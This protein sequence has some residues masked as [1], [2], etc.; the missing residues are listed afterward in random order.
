[1][2]MIIAILFFVS[3]MLVDE[4]SAQSTYSVSVSRHAAVPALSEAHVRKILEDASKMLQKNSVSNGDTDVA[5]DVTF[6]LVGPVRTFGSADTPPNIVDE[7]HR[8]AVHKVDSDV[9]GVDFH[10]EVVD[11]IRFCRPNLDGPFNGCAFPPDF[12]SIIVVHPGKHP[13]APPLEFPDHLLWAHEFGHLTGLGH[14][15]SKCALMTSCSV[16]DLASVTRVR[17]NNEECRCLRGGLGFCPLPAAVN[18]QPAD[19]Q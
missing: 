11:E 9:I 15:H 6:T 18:C 19:C 8:D 10:I 3:L 5:C 2:Q 14:R 12:R 16:A 1:M 4:A 13:D 7:Q 17:V